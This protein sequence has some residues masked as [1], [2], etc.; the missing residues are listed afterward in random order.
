VQDQV[1]GRPPGAVI[2]RTRS[3][4]SFALYGALTL[5]WVLCLVVSEAAQSTAAGRIEAGVLFGVLVLVG[6]AACVRVYL[7]RRQLEVGRDAIATRR[8]AKGTAFTLTGD[9][10]DTLR[11]LPRFTLYGRVRS[12]RLMFLGRGGFILLSGFRPDQVRRVCEA[13]G[14][15]FDGDPSLA[16]RDVQ[17]WL[18]RGQSVEAVQLLELFGPFPDAAAD[19][20]PHTGLEAAVYEDI[21]DKLIR[22]ARASAADAYR[23]AAAGQRAFAGFAR[24][25]DEGAARMAEASRIEGK[26]P[27]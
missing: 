25:P 10:G 23:R 5:L 17:S 4:G 21:G 27:N 13:Q 7:I 22:S 20:E 24:S 26:A 11:I 16:V 3:T 14:W 2:V 1:S 19:G 9:P 6:V 15:R 8:G 18:H 12:P